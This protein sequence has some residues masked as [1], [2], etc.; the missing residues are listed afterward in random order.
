MRSRNP[1]P[2]VLEYA[3]L[4]GPAMKESVR[5]LTK[6]GFLNFTAREYFYKLPE[7]DCLRL[8]K[9]P[10]CSTSSRQI[11]VSYRLEG[12]LQLERQLW[13]VSSSGNC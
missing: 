9:S 10:Q 8:K 6:C 5:Q 11:D 13:T 3:Y 2:T 12:T 4:L 1:T 7:E